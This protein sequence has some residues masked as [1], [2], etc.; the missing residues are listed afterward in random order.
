[1]FVCAP[2]VALGY[3][4]VGPNCMLPRQTA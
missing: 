2:R 1:M 3:R 4:T